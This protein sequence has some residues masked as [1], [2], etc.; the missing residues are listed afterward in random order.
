[1]IESIINTR[2]GPYMYKYLWVYIYLRYMH[3]YRE[4]YI[5]ICTYACIYL[6]MHTCKRICIYMYIYICMYTCSA[7]ASK[8]A[9]GLTIS[10]NMC[11][12]VCIYMYIIIYKYLCICI[13][14]IMCVNNTGILEP[15]ILVCLWISKYIISM[16]ICIYIFIYVF[17]YT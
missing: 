10:V 17:M 12:D 6:Y 16:Y 9:I 5:H 8:A 4:E 11:R 14:T 15:Y 13:Y 7:S 2:N 1:M 3:I